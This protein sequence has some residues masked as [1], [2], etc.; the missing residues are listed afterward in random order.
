M[1]NQAI[2]DFGV[3]DSVRVGKKEPNSEWW[4]E[5]AK[6]ILERKEAV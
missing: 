5:D 2:F 1:V 3:F 4:Y 6:G